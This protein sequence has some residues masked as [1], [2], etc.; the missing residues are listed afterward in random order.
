MTPQS[1]AELADIIA[2]AK[3]PMSIRGGGTRG[4]SGRGIH[5]RSRVLAV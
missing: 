2:A 4:S 5:C 3:G 1:E